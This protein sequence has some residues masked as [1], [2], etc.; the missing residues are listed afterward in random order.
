[1]KSIM[2]MLTVGCTVLAFAGTQRWQ[3]HR[4]A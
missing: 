1:M 4:S 2:M 3:A